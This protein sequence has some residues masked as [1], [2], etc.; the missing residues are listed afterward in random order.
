MGSIYFVGT[1]QGTSITR[2]HKMTGATA[3]ILRE[4]LHLS[5]IDVLKDFHVCSTSGYHNPLFY[6]VSAKNKHLVDDEFSEEIWQEGIMLS[7]GFKFPIRFI[8]TERDGVSYHFIKDKVV[9]PNYS[10]LIPFIIPSFEIAKKYSNRL[11]DE[12]QLSQIKQLY[13][14][15]CEWIAKNEYIY[16]YRYY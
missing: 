12:E 16:W 4:F 6:C 10:E 1:F 14:S 9:T 15:V 2:A 3:S 8:G 7:D 11:K 5:H 13:S